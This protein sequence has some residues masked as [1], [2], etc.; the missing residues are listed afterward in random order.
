MISRIAAGIALS[1]CLAACGNLS[2]AAAEP[3]KDADTLL[4]LSQGQLIGFKASNGAHVWRGIPFGAST[5]GQNRWRA[6]RPVSA[7][8]DIKSATKFGPPCP[9]FSREKS[10]AGELIGSEDCLYLNVYTPP[11]AQGRDLPVMVYIHGGANVWGTGSDNDGSKLAV[12]QNIILVTVQ[13]RLGPLGF[14][15]HQSLRKTATQPLDRAANFALLDL[16]ANLT[17][18]RDEISVFGGDPSNVTIFGESAG[19]QN[20]AA[21]IG[22]PLATGLFHQAIMQSGGFDSVS[23]DKAEFENSDFFNPASVVINKLGH[24]DLDNK[25]TAAALRQTSL[26][27]LFATYATREEAAE[28]RIRYNDGTPEFPNIPAIIS[29]GVSL[30]KAPLRSLLSDQETFNAV[31]MIMGTNRD[32]LKALFQSDPKLVEK[33]LGLFPAAR[34]QHRYDLIS[35]YASRLWRIHTVDEPAAMMDRAGH[36]DIWAY[37]F[38]WDESGSVGMTD[39]SKLLGASHGFEIPFVFGTFDDFADGSK[40]LFPSKHAASRGALSAAMGQYWTS[41]ARDGQPKAESGPAWPRYTSGSSHQLIRFDSERDNGIGT[42][43]GLD[44]MKLW[45]ADLQQDKRMSPSDQCAILNVFKTY[46]DGNV[47]PS[48]ARRQI[49]ALGQSQCPAD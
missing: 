28:T 44:S 15:A 32:E 42:L 10:N 18:V 43:P 21:L 19:G 41:F 4:A 16:I 14:F 12:E 13:Y 7:W 5:A 3:V 46:R 45:I 49:H 37:R 20:I 26:A 35:E 48:A 33:K 11:N 22:S 17:W 9:Q 1:L 47:I 2:E 36:K 39:L 25:E 29:D 38:D 30:P 24:Q 31:P 34:N 23:L 27:D 40:Y 6:P 8:S